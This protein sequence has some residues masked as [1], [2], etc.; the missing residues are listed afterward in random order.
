MDI[1]DLSKLSVLGKS[2]P[3]TD[4]KIEN[5]EILDSKGCIHVGGLSDVNYEKLRNR[6]IQASKIEKQI[7]KR[8]I[9]KINNTLK[10]NRKKFK[11]NKSLSQY[12]LYDK[13]VK[14][15]LDLENNVSNLKNSIEENIDYGSPISQIGGSRLADVVDVTDRGS[16]NARWHIDPTGLPSLNARQY[17][18][19]NNRAIFILKLLVPQQGIKFYI[20]YENIDN[21]TANSQGLYHNYYTTSEGYWLSYAH[22]SDGDEG[23]HVLG[24]EVA[25]NF[26]INPPFNTHYYSPCVRQG[27]PVHNAVQPQ[28]KESTSDS[29]FLY[30]C[31][32]GGQDGNIHDIGRG[33]G[34]L[35]DT[36]SN[37]EA[38]NLYTFN[39]MKS[40]NIPKVIEA[41]DILFF[42]MC[43][44]EEVNRYYACEFAELE[45]A[46]VGIGVHRKFF[47]LSDSRLDL[48]KTSGQ[49]CY[50]QRYDKL[51][52]YWSKCLNNIN[53]INALSHLHYELPANRDWVTQ[54]LAGVAQGPNQLVGPIYAERN[55]RELLHYIDFVDTARTNMKNRFIQWV[56]EVEQLPNGNL[57]KDRFDEFT[58]LFCGDDPNPIY[59]RFL[60]NDRQTQEPIGR[61]GR[62]CQIRG[63]PRINNVEQT[64][65]KSIWSTIRQGQANT[66][67][68]RN[69]NY[70]QQCRERNFE[71]LIDQASWYNNKLCMITSR[72][73][74][75]LP[76][77]DA[78]TMLEVAA[79]AWGDTFYEKNYIKRL[80]IYNN[81]AP[82]DQP[83][84][85]YI[86]QFWSDGVGNNIVPPELN[87]IVKLR[88]HED[89]PGANLVDPERPYLWSEAKYYDTIYRGANG[90]W[91]ECNG[92]AA[93]PA[94]EGER[95][96]IFKQYA[97]CSVS[98]NVA[99]EFSLRGDN[100][101]HIYC[102]KVAPDVPYIPY[103][104]LAGD[105]ESC[106]DEG[107][108]LLPP[109]CI[110][111]IPDQP[112]L[113]DQ[114]IVFIRGFIYY[115]D[116]PIMR[117]RTNHY[118]NS[119]SPIVHNSDSN[120]E[121]LPACCEFGSLCKTRLRIPYRMLGDRYDHEN[122]HLNFENQ[123][124][125]FGQ[126]KILRSEPPIE[127]NGD[128]VMDRSLRE[129][130]NDLNI[131]V[132]MGGKISNS[133][134]KQ[135]KELLKPRTSVKPG[136]FSL[137]Q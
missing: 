4:M 22:T 120:G 21:L 17:A 102:F 61:R 136:K 41:G 20:C 80:L 2:L 90:A 53:Q 126:N 18:I 59:R 82:A 36:T 81:I 129:F 98:I 101:P 56:Q 113:N 107:E 27:H 16:Q 125:N 33:L 35:I 55:L 34:L 104:T 105:S 28:I 67:D 117:N 5:P 14:G 23:M 124:V 134:K 83:L 111:I 74:L 42:E 100:R 9:L 50:T 19:Q 132:Q 48:K 39:T 24:N 122:L 13:N 31:L 115:A 109:G 85:Y 77:R 1:T 52:K 121:L 127:A 99:H 45:Y 64:C 123:R 12:N 79:D 32:L 68:N 89:P 11:V 71:R 78:R 95:R 7:H 51:I 3:I 128:V 25:R 72:C 26:N 76:S 96:Y 112:E 6:I 119:R 37:S 93:Q 8:N 130:W 84:D 133:R 108:I 106:Y 38:Y 135:I 73:P 69:R 60:E 62:H 86:S 57:D 66:N 54:M 75:T 43:S 88:K 47:R 40:D 103:S 114:N 97:S 30:Q 44:Q 15:Y 118:I 49:V 92:C 110:L 70:S 65:M 10:K 116:T 46:N 131:Q 91:H 29:Q 94:Q 63:G 137:S 58:R 87:G